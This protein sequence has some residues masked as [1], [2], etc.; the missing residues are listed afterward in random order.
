M[1]RSSREKINKQTQALNDTLDQM[2][3]IDIY[4]ASHPKAAE[5]TF[6]S[7]AYGTFCSKDHILGL[8]ASLSKFMKTE[9]YQASF[10]TTMLSMRLEIDY[11]KKLQKKPETHGG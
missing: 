11:K 1:G 7:S 2:D 8:K 4:K 3:L 9:S 6:L 10:P 5:Y